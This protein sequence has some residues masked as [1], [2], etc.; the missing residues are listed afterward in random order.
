MLQRST[1]DGDDVVAQVS[2]VRW[3][4]RSDSRKT[5]V[6]RAV[7]RLRDLGVIEAAQAR[8]RSG[9]FDAGSYRLVVP[10]VCLSPAGPSEPSVLSPAARPSCA[11]APSALSLLLCCS[12]VS[13][14]VRPPLVGQLSLLP[15]VRARSRVRRSLRSFFN[16]Q[17]GAPTHAGGSGHDP[18][19]DAV[20]RPGRE[21]LRPTTP[22]PPRKPMVSCRVCGP[23]PKLRDSALPARSR[24]RPSKHSC[25]ATTR[26]P[27]C[28]SVGSWWIA[29]TARQHHPCR[30]RL[31]R[32]LLG[33]E[34][35]EPLVG[36]DRRPGSVLDAHNVAVQSRGSPTSRPTAARPGCG[37]A[38]GVSSPEHRAGSPWP[39]SSSR[40]PTRTT[41]SSTPMPSSPPR[42]SAPDGR[43]LALGW[44][45][46][47]EDP[48]GS[49]SA[50]PVGAAGRAHPPL[51]RRLGTGRQRPGRDRRCPRRAARGVSPSAPRPGRSA[52]RDGARPRRS[53][54]AE[55]RDPTTSRSGRRSN[56]KPRSTPATEDRAPV[57]EAHDTVDRR[58]RKRSAGTATRLEPG[59]SH[60]RAPAG[61]SRRSQRPPSTTSSTVTAS[62]PHG[63]RSTSCGSLRHSAPRPGQDG[64]NWVGSSDARDRHR[65]RRVCRSRPDRQQPTGERADGRSVWIEPIAKQSTSDAC[66]RPGG[67]H[68]HLTSRRPSPD[69]S[70][71]T[72]DPGARLDDGQRASASAVAGHD[73]LV[74]VVG[75]A[76][77]GKTTMLE[78]AVLDLHHQQRPVVGIAPT[79]RAASVLKRRPGAESDTVAKLLYEL[80]HP[81]APAVADP[82]RPSDDRRRRGRHVEHHRPLPPRGARRAAT[83]A[84]GAGR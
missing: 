32:H 4:R 39:C 6:A 46:P 24:P 78:A 10:A 64:T 15:E 55:G 60:G 58:S 45:L 47:E 50:L 68:P 81:D 28:S 79:A 69:P 37:T 11:A 59:P 30:R 74:V 53:S 36:S 21:H 22:A 61:A 2:F 3:R 75:P 83:V 16:F 67:T 72:V 80:D 84:P 65:A 31:R 56:A 20:Q 44:P 52:M 41:R 40:R 9:V 33:P 13:V 42:S 23:G 48:A 29:S 12:S 71:S 82:S 63:D 1:G 35:G 51:R 38:V 34:V 19:D 14:S 49:R 62:R 25:R 18:G 54:N 27:A 17:T 70:P 26:P 77:A 73:R 43:W 7:G 57:A 76:G 66:P 8:S 5:P